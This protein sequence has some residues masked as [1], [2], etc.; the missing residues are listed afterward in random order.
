MTVNICFEV[1][2][3]PGAAQ[4]ARVAVNK[5]LGRAM[6]YTP[7]PTRRWQSM[8]AQVSA[9]HMPPALLD[10]PIGLDLWC[11]VPRPA[12]LDGRKHA[13]GWLWCDKRPDWDNYAK[14]VCDALKAFWRDDARIS[15]A[16]VGKVY[17]EK[18]ARA[19]LLVRIY[20]LDNILPEDVATRW[21]LPTD[22]APE[23]SSQEF[24]DTCESF[25]G[26]DPRLAFGRD[27]AGI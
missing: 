10:E 16:R 6:V 7:A 4:R 17:S 12:S 24:I 22:S 20:T 27:G 19:R 14:N 21:G 8:L 18:G 9:Q 11:V 13:A 3:E 25:A 26:P 2:L 15:C 5:H 23:E 1:P